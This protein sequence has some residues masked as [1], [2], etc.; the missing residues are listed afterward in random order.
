MGEVSG[1]SMGE[2]GRLKVRWGNGDDR[3]SSGEVGWGNWILVNDARQSPEVDDE[4]QSAE[5]CQ[6]GIEFVGSIGS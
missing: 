4:A 2:A 5:P 3:R 1:I 6:F